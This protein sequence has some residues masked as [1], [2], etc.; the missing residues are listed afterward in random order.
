MR[1]GDVDSGGA[2][3]GPVEIGHGKSAGKSLTPQDAMVFEMTT[4]AYQLYNDLLP[5]AHS[6]TVVHPPH[7]G[8][9]TR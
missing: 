5:H 6:V 1:N 4:N 8:L 9:I 7:V 2:T 3:S